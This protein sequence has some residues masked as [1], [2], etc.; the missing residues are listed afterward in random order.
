MFSYNSKTSSVLLHG[1]GI[2]LFSHEVFHFT[3]LFIILILT[4]KWPKEFHVLVNYCLTVLIYKRERKILRHAIFYY[5]YLLINIYLLIYVATAAPVS[6]QKKMQSLSS[7]FH[8]RHKKQPKKKRTIF[9]CAGSNGL[10]VKQLG[11]IKIFNWTQM[12]V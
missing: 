6:K 9:F 8:L 5:V 1:L 3:I 11:E 12:E 7:H 4:I 10:L 2:T